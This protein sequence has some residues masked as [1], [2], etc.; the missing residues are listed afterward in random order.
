MFLIK[1]HTKTQSSQYLKLA[2]LVY[3]KLQTKYEQ[4]KIIKCNNLYLG[5][6]LTTDFCHLLEFY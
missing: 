2:L 6:T 4:P 3:S 5:Q 1:I